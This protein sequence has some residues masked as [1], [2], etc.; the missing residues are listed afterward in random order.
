ME[1]L[2]TIIGILVL[3]IAIIFLLPVKFIIKNDDENRFYFRVKFLWF[4][5]LKPKKSKDKP[6]GV[7]KKMGIDGLE[8]E[9]LKARIK[10]NGIVE[11]STVAVKIIKTV[12]LRLGGVLKHSRVDKFN[13]TLVCS[14]DDAASAAMRYGS[15]CAIV[16]PLLGFINSIIKVKPK[17]RNIDISCKYGGVS[18]M[19]RYDFL[20]SVRVVFLLI[21]ALKLLCEYIK[22]KRGNQ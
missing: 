19:L 6:Q 12:F 10:E 21:A 20:L 1:I 13:F 18:E 8:L 3:L 4:T 17:N 5:F 11:T 16:Y 2:F 15:C 14:S 7:R 22:L 9:S